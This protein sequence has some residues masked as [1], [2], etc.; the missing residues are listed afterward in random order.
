MIYE[1]DRVVNEL[2]Y[3]MDRGD[4]EFGWITR[5]AL[6]CTNL[7]VNTDTEERGTR[8]SWGKLMHFNAHHD[9]NY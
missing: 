6:K 2:G 4:M 7:G 3:S 9:E 8:G 1:L 5:N